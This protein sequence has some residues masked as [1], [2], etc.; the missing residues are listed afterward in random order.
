MIDEM[1]RTVGDLLVQF[2]HSQTRLRD[3]VERSNQLESHLFAMQQTVLELDT[4]I[5]LRATPA[6]E[7]G[8][9]GRWADFDLLEVDQYNQLHSLGR[10]VAES[11]LD[12]REMARELHERLLG[13][14]N[15]MRQQQRTGREVNNAVMAARMVR[16]STQ[17]NRWQRTVRQTCR[18]TGKQAELTLEGGG[19]AIDTDILNALVEPLLHLLRN[20]VDH[21]IESPERRLRADKPE[22]GQ[23]RL[24]FRQDGSRIL[25]ELSDDGRGLDEQ[26]IAARARVLKLFPEDHLP[27]AAEVQHAVLASGFSTRDEVTET[28]GRGIGLDVVR[29]AVQKIGGTLALRSEPGR[30]LSVKLVLPQSLT[31]THLLFVRVGEAQF[32]L[33]S[34]RIDQILFSD[35]GAIETIGGRRIFR[36]GGDECPIHRLADLLGL[37]GEASLDEDAPRPLVLMHTDEGRIALLIDQVVESREA[38]VK[39]LH[40]HFPG[41]RGAGGACILADGDV[42]IVL[43]LAEVELAASPESRRVARRISELAMPDTQRPRVLIADDSLSAR[44]SLARMIED[45]GYTPV[46]AVDGVDALERIEAHA[47]DVLLLDLE[48]PRMNGLELTAHLR[49]RP[50]TADLP[51]IMITSR[52]TAKHRKQADRVG[53]SRYV[54]KPYDDHDLADLLG[55][56]VAG[57]LDGVTA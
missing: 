23:I 6:V 42:A 35:A 40:V 30:G 12:A 3:A 17:E 39:S 2:G 38:V 25:V 20:A 19:L 47:P 45:L 34:L 5:D 13:M 16:V 24:Q 32:A 36:F 53:V 28:S 15:L 21:G 31:S 46:T 56:A 29:S 10:R 48:M 26:A 55:D 33:P 11:A 7:A 50:E 27:D 52:S 4:L 44:R 22:T 18:A 1:L 54:T 43:D 51:V 49:S 14:Q 9:R 8:G 57:R 37:P 41:L